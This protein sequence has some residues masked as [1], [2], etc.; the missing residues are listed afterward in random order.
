MSSSVRRA[1]ELSKKDSR[2][3]SGFRRGD[4]RR[5]AR[6]ARR[7]GAGR[8]GR[9]S[10]WCEGRRA[11]RGRR[12]LRGRARRCGRQAGW[13]RCPGVASLPGCREGRGGP[14]RWG[15]PARTGASARGCPRVRRRGGP[16]PET[17]SEGQP[18]DVRMH[19]RRISAGGPVRLRTGMYLRWCGR[20]FAERGRARVG[21]E[22]GDGGEIDCGGEGCELPC[23]E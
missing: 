20:A 5:A 15:I 18:C 12:A 9:F 8:E 4:L 3:T 14:S 22:N 1:R 23:R 7:R 21:V 19:V 11:S 17:R 10:G 2:E 16:G 13:Y 6:R